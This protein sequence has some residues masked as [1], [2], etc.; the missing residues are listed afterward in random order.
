MLPKGEMERSGEWRFWE[1][2]GNLA[3]TGVSHDELWLHYVGS[4][5][6]QW[7]VKFTGRVCGQAVAQREKPGMR[8]HNPTEGE[9]TAEL[10]HSRERPL[11]AMVMT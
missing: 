6:A 10:S 4:E 11:P 8:A 1:H 3:A 5:D 9:G 7:G 2:R